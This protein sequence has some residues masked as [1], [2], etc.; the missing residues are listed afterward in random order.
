M[1]LSSTLQNRA[2][3]ENLPSLH[4]RKA[5]SS[6][7]FWGCYQLCNYSSSYKTTRIPFGRLIMT[8]ERGEQSHYMSVTVLVFY[9]KGIVL[10]Y[11]LYWT[12]MFLRYSYLLIVKSPFSCRKRS[13]N[14]FHSLQLLSSFYSSLSPVNCNYNCVNQ[15]PSSRS[16]GPDLTLP[17]SV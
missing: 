10:N 16:K 8:L 5:F 4:F 3:E 13:K 9:G 2:C 11:R 15:N 14:I 17:S 12:E 1:C 7:T 6:L